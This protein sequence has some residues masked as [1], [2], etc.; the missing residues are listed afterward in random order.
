VS[1]KCNRDKEEDRRRHS[2]GQSQSLPRR[3][4]GQAMQ[5]LWESEAENIRDALRERK[6]I[7]GQMARECSL[8]DISQMKLKAPDAK[9]R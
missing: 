3:L 7:K 5:K 2:C 8:A 6:Q 4:A 9:R 1:I